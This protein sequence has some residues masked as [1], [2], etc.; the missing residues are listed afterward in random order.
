MTSFGRTFI[1]RRWTDS[2]GET[3]KV[4]ETFK[5][6]V[7]MKDRELQTEVIYKRLSPLFPYSFDDTFTSKLYKLSNG[8]GLSY[9]GDSS[10]FNER[11]LNLNNFCKYTIKLL[12][13]TIRHLI[14]VLV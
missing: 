4:S 10:L 9:L 13:H 11:F 12:S 2:R 5:I 7:F 3:N 8:T 14:K 6:T 1:N